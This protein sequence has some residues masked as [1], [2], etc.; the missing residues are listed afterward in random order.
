MRLLFKRSNGDAATARLQTIETRLAQ[1]EQTQAVLWSLAPQWIPSS[2]VH[3]LATGWSVETSPAAIWFRHEDHED[4]PINLP[5]PALEDQHEIQRDT[6]MRLGGPTGP[7]GLP[8]IET[9]YRPRLMDM[10][11]R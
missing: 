5:L 6:Y 11:Q 1:V 7:T 2:V 4:F 9:P 3:A 10:A 8:R